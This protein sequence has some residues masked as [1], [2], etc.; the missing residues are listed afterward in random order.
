MRALTIYQ[1]WA[2]L[3]MAGAKPYE[4]RKRPAPRS[5]IGKRIV[6][7]A[8]ARPMDRGEVADLMNRIGTS[9]DGTG[10]DPAKALDLLDRVW[11]DM[12][13]LPLAAGLGTAVLGES[14]P[15]TEL[16]PDTDSDRIDHHKWGWPMLDIKHFEPIVPARGM[17][18]FWNWPFPEA[19][20]A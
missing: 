18:G 6:I 17:Q 10:L 19:R 4:F 5:L 13:I 11:K 16:Y 14:K 15:A 7:H 8:S 3:I 9:E 12:S 1:P 2:S 20:T